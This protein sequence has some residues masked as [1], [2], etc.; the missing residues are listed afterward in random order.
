MKLHL[1]SLET[2]KVKIAKKISF[3]FSW[4]LPPIECVINRKSAS[5]DSWLIFRHHMSQF[6]S[7][8][9][10][11][12][13]FL[14]PD[15]LSPKNKQKAHKKNCSKKKRYFTEVINNVIKL[16]M[17][18][19]SNSSDATIVIFRHFVTFLQV[20]LCQKHIFS[21]KLT[22]NMTKDCSLIYQF[23]TWKLQAQN[24]GRTCC[25][26]KL[27]YVFVLTQNNLCAQRDL[28][29]FWACSFYVLNW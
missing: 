14:Y 9:P 4:V 12:S 7:Q 17:E 15:I 25:A 19:H 20:N 22:L 1:N 2:K 6:L 24:T 28:H 21:H 13:L 26:H 23:N 29:M 16:F 5:H 11:T 8:S 18:S 27:F 3:Q 10:S